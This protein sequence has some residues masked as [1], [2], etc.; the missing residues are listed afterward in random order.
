MKSIL[1]ISFGLLI[2]RN[3]SLVSF[4]NKMKGFQNKACNRKIFKVIIKVLPDILKNFGKILV[5]YLNC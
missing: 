2:S 5:P 4:S 3:L 1:H